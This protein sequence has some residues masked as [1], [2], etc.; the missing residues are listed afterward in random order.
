MTLRKLERK[1]DSLI[2]NDELKSEYI[3]SLD[4]SITFYPLKDRSVSITTASFVSLWADAIV[5]VAATIN[6]DGSIMYEGENSIVQMNQ[7]T[8]NAIITGA[9]AEVYAQLTESTRFSGTIN[10]TK[11]FDILSGN[12]LSHIPPLFGRVGF[13]ETLQGLEY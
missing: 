5:P 13:L 4:E 8:D 10:Y 6:G 2:P 12:P 9:R 3:Y 11:G 1:V 7:N